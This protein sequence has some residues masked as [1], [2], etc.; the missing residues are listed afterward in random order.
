VLEPNGFHNQSIERI[1]TRKKEAKASISFWSARSSLVVKQLFEILK[2]MCKNTAA[3]NNE[4]TGVKAFQKPLLKRERSLRMCLTL[5]Q[6]SNN[7]KYLRVGNLP[8]QTKP[9][10][11]MN[12]LNEAMRQANMCYFYETPIRNILVHNCLA[13]GSFRTTSLAREALELSGIIYLGSQLNIGRPRSYTGSK[14]KDTS[15]IP[16]KDVC[17]EKACISQVQAELD[18]IVESLLRACMQLQQKKK[19]DKDSRVEE[20]RTKRAGKLLESAAK[21]LLKASSQIADDRFLCMARPQGK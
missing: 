19:K 11:L 7:P 15:T 8:S 12:F 18:Q 4:K 1:N 17:S 9:E 10:H 13:Y 3:I 14:D 21:S 20:E 2:R 16:T 5:K 6:S